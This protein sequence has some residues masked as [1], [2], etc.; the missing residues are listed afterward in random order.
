M[1]I[2]Y[3]CRKG[4]NEE[5][6]Y[7]IRSIVKNLPESRIW[8]VGYKPDWYVGGF[9]EAEDIGSKFTNIFNAMKVAANDKRISNNFIF[10]NDD[11]FLLKPIK[12]IPRLHGG[13][14]IDK[15]QEYRRLTD[16]GGTYVSLLS[17]TYKKLVMAGIADPIDYDIHVP[18][19][20]N[21][22][23]LDLVIDGATLPRSMYGNKFNISGK[24]MVDVKKYNP[25]SSLSSRS[26]NLADDLLFVST[27]DKS[28]IELRDSVLKEMFPEP[29]MYE[30]PQ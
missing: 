3:I 23:N 11:F 14:L 10:M 28:F 18:M 1:D 22:K 4:D 12:R 16:G 17:K 26:P 6:R 27:D 25:R 2:V 24:E 15:I 19:Y 20:F 9:I 7:S 5:L 29:S 8:L 30:Y 13:R 21:K